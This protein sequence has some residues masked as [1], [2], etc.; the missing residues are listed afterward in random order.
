MPYL[1]SVQKLLLLEDDGRTD[2]LLELVGLDGM[3]LELELTGGGGAGA[4][5][6]VCPIGV[7][8]HRAHDE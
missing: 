6:E 1:T 2:E 4:G 7:G 8:M 5:A 3:A